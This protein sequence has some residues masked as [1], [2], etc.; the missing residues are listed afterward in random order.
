MPL[1]SM[2]PLTFLL[3]P[4]RWLRAIAEHRAT[5]SAA[6][7]FAY[8]LCLNKIDDADLVG[9]DLSAWRLAFNGAEPVNPTTLRR[10]TERFLPYGLHSDALMPVY[11]LAEAAVGLAFPPV[12]RG[13]VFDRIRRGELLTTGR[14]QPADPGAAPGDCM[15]FV[16]CGRPLP[17]YELRVVDRA[18]SELADR[19]EGHI[20][21]RGPSATSGYFR[22]PDATHDLFHG[23]WLATGDLGYLAGGDP[24]VTGRDKDLIIRAGRNLHPEEIEAAIGWLPGVRKGCVAVFA[25]PDPGGER[26]GND[27]SANGL[28]GAVT[29]ILAGIA[30]VGN[31]G[32]EPAGAR[33]PAR[34]EEQHELDEML[35][36]G[37]PGRLH[38]VHVLATQLGHHGS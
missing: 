2:S 24:F 11:G 32:S 38:D 33:P 22:N 16:A 8:E 13:P 34:V 1:V 26:V 5:I 21:F 28:T 35:V 18:D 10:F 7:N 36:D 25:V 30:E 15:E 4:A 23:D 31:D 12:G 9:V 29:A 17:G 3:R 27:P 20:Q 19:T 37:R 6:P 14:A